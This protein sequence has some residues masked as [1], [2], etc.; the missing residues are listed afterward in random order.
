[1]AICLVATTFLD[2]LALDLGFLTAALLGDAFLTGDAFF[3][4]VILLAFRL[5]G[6][7]RADLDGDAACCTEEVF[8]TTTSILF[9]GDAFLAKGFLALLAVGDFLAPPTR[10]L[11]AAFLGDFLAVSP[12]EYRPKGCCFNVPS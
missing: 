1:M 3:L 5:A 6:D 4:G 12:N 2:D 10:R 8:G 7:L 11:G 9:L